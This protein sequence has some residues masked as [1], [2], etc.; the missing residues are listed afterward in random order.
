MKIY[1]QH[2]NQRQMKEEEWKSEIEN[3]CNECKKKEM[4]KYKHKYKIKDR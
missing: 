2:I 3:K 4:N 1:T